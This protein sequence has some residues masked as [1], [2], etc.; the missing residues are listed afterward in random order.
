MK[1]WCLVLACG[2]NLLADDYVEEGNAFPDHDWCP[3]CGFD[4]AVVDHYAYQ[5]DEL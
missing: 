2:H 3:G 5:D 4:V 1:R